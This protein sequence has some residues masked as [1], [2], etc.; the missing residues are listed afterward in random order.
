MQAVPAREEE[1]EAMHGILLLVL[2]HGNAASAAAA[3]C[4]TR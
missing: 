1:A 3:C 4:G 2:G